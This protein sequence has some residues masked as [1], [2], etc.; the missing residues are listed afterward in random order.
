VIAALHAVLAQADTNVGGDAKPESRGG[1]ASVRNVIV[2]MPGR[3]VAAAE[4]PP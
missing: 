2:K 3:S 4:P 1:I